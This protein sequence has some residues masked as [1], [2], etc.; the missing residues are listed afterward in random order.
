MDAKFDYGEYIGFSDKLKEVDP[1]KRPI[2]FDDIMLIMRD[3]A[4]T[5][6]IQVEDIRNELSG[7]RIRE[8]WIYS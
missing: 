4:A 3:I 5:L 7:K 2:R 1:S 6:S 8:T